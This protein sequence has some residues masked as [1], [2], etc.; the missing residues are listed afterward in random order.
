MTDTAKLE[1]VRYRA[2][3]QAEYSKE[4]IRQRFNRINSMMEDT[5]REVDR[6]MV[7]DDGDFVDLAS[8]AMNTVEN[9]MRN[10]NAASLMKDIATYKAGLEVV[11]VIDSLMEQ[12]DE[13][14][15]GA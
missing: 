2:N 10:I 5:I 3:N 13:G 6:Y 1:G 7:R 11:A 8:W 14:E 4:N 9:L 12:E 15:K